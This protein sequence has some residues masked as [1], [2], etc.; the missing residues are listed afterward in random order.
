MFHLKQT[1]MGRRDGIG[2]NP[3]EV[4]TGGSIQGHPWLHGEL[5]ASLKKTSMMTCLVENELCFLLSHNFSLCKQ[6][7][8]SFSWGP[9]HKKNDLVI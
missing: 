7:R 3:R 8:F 1:S 5:E 4:E 9:P 6:E 2:L